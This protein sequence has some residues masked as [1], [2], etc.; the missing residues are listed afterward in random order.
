[1]HLLTELDKMFDYYYYLAM[2][3]LII[4]YQLTSPV[5]ISLAEQNLYELE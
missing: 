2:A 3:C 1:M 5:L 4:V